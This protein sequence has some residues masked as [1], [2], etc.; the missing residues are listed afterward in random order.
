MLNITHNTIKHKEELKHYNS[1]LLLEKKTN[2]RRLIKTMYGL[3][4][5]FIII[6]FLPW[7]QNIQSMA[8]VTALRPD[9]R[10]QTI[11][12]AIAGRIEKWFVQE[13]QFVKKGDTILYISEIKEDYLDPELLSRTEEQIKSKEFAVKSYMEKVK[14]N[15]NQ[16]DALISAS[17]LKYEQAENKLIQ[18]NLKVKSDSV[19]LTA[20][21]LNYKIAKEQFVRMENL[22]KEG[23]KSL[24]DLETRKLKMQEMEAK[25]IAQE[26]KLISSKNEVINA[27]IELQ[28]INADYRDKI[29]KSE[30]EK[31]AT[32]SNMYDA[33]ATVTKLQN[34]FMN[35]SIRSGLYY[36][37]APQDGYITQAIK[38]GV[39][40][41][42]KEGSEIISIMPYNYELAVE[43]FVNPMDIP[44]LEKKQHVQIQ[45]DGW[46]SIIFS[47]WPGISYGT[48]GGEVVAIDNF[49][50]ENGKYRVLVAE[51]K[52]YPAWPKE[53]RLG[54]GARTIT[55]LKDV[56]VWYE[57][58]RQINGFPPDYYKTT[59]TITKNTDEKKK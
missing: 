14:A 2:S 29:A 57:L 41:T 46:P 6:L 45:F 34:Q 55:L 39:G 35:Y 7:T 40:E 56:P 53:I 50:N 17:K 9:Q 38:S 4:I 12:S 48:Y 15:D 31:Y 27:K 18:A 26:N 28:S 8:K 43:M 47:G 16:I 20:A 54:A 23:L 32:L 1:F 30:S 3:F 11:H 13:G 51:D 22:Y 33:E 49:V 10:P 59:N 52:N 36:I 19:D 25:L 37:T 44:L 58:W 5:I 21:E 42:L 24:T